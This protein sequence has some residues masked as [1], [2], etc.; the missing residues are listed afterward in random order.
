MNQPNELIEIVN[1]ETG[2]RVR[3]TRKVLASYYEHQ[4]YVEA[5]DHAEEVPR[6]PF[7]EVSPPKIASTRQP[8]LRGAAKLAAEKKAAK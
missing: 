3:T 7:L 1:L 2:D 6:G 5:D 4:G 8:A